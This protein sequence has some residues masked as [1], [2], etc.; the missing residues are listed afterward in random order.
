[1]ID[2]PAIRQAASHALTLST[3]RP[4]AEGQGQG[5]EHAQLEGVVPGGCRAGHGAGLGLGHV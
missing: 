3:R 2:V 1:V 5:E 4:M